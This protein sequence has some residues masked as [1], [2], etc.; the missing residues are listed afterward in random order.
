MQ[1]LDRALLVDI[2]QPNP[3]PWI[4][5]VARRVARGWRDAAT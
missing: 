1:R 5:R 3:A 4:V 2:V